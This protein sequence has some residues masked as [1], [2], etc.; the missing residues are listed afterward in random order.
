[1]VLNRTQQQGWKTFEITSNK[2]RIN[3]PDVLDTWKSPPDLSSSKYCLEGSCA[4]PAVFSHLAMGQV[5]GTPCWTP[6]SWQL[7]VTW[8]YLVLMDVHPKYAASLFPRDSIFM[9]LS[10]TCL[11]CIMRPC[12]LGVHYGQRSLLRST[13]LSTIDL[14]RLHQMFAID[15]CNEVWCTVTWHDMTWLDIT[16][17]K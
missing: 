8:Y 9:D 1:M 4:R 14:S 5:N 10:W 11:M 3:W 7:A 13:S 12:G 17:Y 15:V 16:W 2:E 6:N